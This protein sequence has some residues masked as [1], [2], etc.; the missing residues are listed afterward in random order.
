MAPFTLRWKLCSKYCC[1]QSFH[2]HL[3]INQNGAFVHNILYISCQLR[4]NGERGYCLWT[5]TSFPWR[6]HVSPAGGN[7]SQIMYLDRVR[8]DKAG[9]VGNRNTAHLVVP[10][11]LGYV[12]PLCGP[13]SDLKHWQTIM[14]HSGFYETPNSLVNHQLFSLADHMSG[15]SPLFTGV[16]C[17][18]CLWR[19]TPRLPG[20]LQRRD[21]IHTL[22]LQHNKIWISG[23]PTVGSL[24]GSI[25]WIVGRGCGANH[26]P[27]TKNNTPWELVCWGSTGCRGSGLFT[28]CCW[29]L[30]DCAGQP[31][32]RQPAVL[33]QAPGGEPH[34]ITHIQS[35]DAIYGK[36]QRCVCFF[37]LL[38]IQGPLLFN[39][40]LPLRSKPAQT[41]TRRIKGRVGSSC[42]S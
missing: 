33:P 14:K 21:A 19:G 22:L 9:Y 25:I 7:L 20:I 37:F 24:A 3:W 23:E 4:E 32:P 29:T 5:C 42:S 34:R 31:A 1:W 27:F 35:L 8:R 36:I 39:N 15:C 41:F 30:A 13:V 12:R 11:G 10:I 26:L 28:V 6:N 17:W 2:R 16:S 40:P 18:C 38:Q